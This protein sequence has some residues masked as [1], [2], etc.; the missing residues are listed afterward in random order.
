MHYIATVAAA[1]ARRSARSAR[2]VG[3]A[4]QPAVGSG[5]APELLRQG[6][7]REGGER[8][9]DQRQGCRARA[10]ER[11]QRHGGGQPDQGGDAQKALQGTEAD[12]PPGKQ[13]ADPGEQHQQDRQ[14][15][16]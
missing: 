12:P 9:Q 1:V 6:R 10:R 8:E 14:R 16:V 7:Q 2:G 4:A 5:A 3:P 13:R 11:E 15:V